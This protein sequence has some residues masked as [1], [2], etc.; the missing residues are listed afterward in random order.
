MNTGKPKV[1]MSPERRAEFN[2]QYP[3]PELRA[4]ARARIKAG[5][6][7][8][9]AAKAAAAKP[10]MGG[11]VTKVTNG[12][13]QVL[14]GAE[15]DAVRA[16]VLA[17]VK[18][19]GGTKPAPG[20]NDPLKGVRDLLGGVG[21]ILQPKLT[22]EQA[23]AKRA[24]YAA[25]RAQAQALVKPKAPAK[26]TP[27]ATTQTPAVRKSISRAALVARLTQPTKRIL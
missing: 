7:A 11:T 16:K 12:K 20:R 21:G 4:E 13:S 24:R 18:G 27:A 2:K 17:A 6:P 23:T 1:H 14:T 26:T 3:T 5:R 25:R 8:R 22:P 10:N 15:A 9:L 19:A